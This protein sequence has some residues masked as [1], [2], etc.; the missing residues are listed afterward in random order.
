[1][2]VN[3]AGYRMFRA[4]RSGVVKVHLGPGSKR[5]IDGWI[6]VDANFISARPDVWADLRNT[7]P[8]PD[9]SVDVIYSHHVIEHLPDTLL[10]FHFRQMFRCLKPG[11]FIRVGG[12]NGDV[13]MRKYLEGDDAWFSDWPDKRRSTGG[14]LVNFLLCRGEHQTILTASYLQELAGDA[15]FGNIAPCNPQTETR[16]PEIIEPRILASENVGPHVDAP[17]TLMLE[18]EKPHAG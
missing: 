7:L 2:R 13:A 17:K 18:A 1:M 5:Y 16:H 6:N 8:F 11:G 10:A 3:G 12:P 14:R 4:P 15:G 9:N